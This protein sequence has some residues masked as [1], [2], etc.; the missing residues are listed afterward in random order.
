MTVIIPSTTC[1]DTP[2]V[3]LTHFEMGS[4]FKAPA[5][6]TETYS[7]EIIFPELPMKR[8]Q[9]IE[10]PASIPILFFTDDG[11]TDSL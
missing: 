10:I 9:P 3:D 11:R 4:G 2:S 8:R 6:F 1:P 5:F 7:I